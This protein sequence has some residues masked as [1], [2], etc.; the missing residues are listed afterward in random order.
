MWGSAFKIKPSQI[1]FITQGFH[2]EWIMRRIRM[3]MWCEWRSCVKNKIV[4]NISTDA[5]DDFKCH[6]Y[7]Y[8]EDNDAD[9]MEQATASAIRTN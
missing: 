5:E 1:V 9:K 3:L 7:L 8:Y 2:K 6:N 4:T